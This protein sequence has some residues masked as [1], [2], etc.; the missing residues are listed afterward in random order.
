[1]RRIVY[2]KGMTRVRY[3]DCRLPV[4]VILKNLK[5]SFIVGHIK[6]EEENDNLYFEFYA[7]V[8]PFPRDDWNHFKEVY[9]IK[10][11]KHTVPVVMG[12]KKSDIMKSFTVPNYKKINRS[13][14]KSAKGLKKYSL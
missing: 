10:D 6:I 4:A 12:A 3:E 14:I 9:D 2:N 13:F 8:D 1:M 11:I 7:L 5:K